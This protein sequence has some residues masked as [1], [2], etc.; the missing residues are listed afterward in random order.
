[1]R[2]FQRR[3]KRC[4]QINGHVS[5]SGDA[6]PRATEQLRPSVIVGYENT[7]ADFRMSSWEH[8]H[9]SD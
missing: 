5:F 4:Q 3:N 7:G 1:M 6:F 2:Q 8:G 9:E